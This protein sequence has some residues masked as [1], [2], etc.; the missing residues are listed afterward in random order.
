MSDAAEKN[1][2]LGK[3][4]FS[5]QDFKKAKECFTE[6]IESGSDFADVYNMLGIIHHDEGKLE[7]A[8]HYFEKALAINPNYSEASI[9]LAVVYSDIGKFDEAMRV[10][11][12]A[13]ERASEKSTQHGIDPYALGKLSNLH[14][15]LADIY[16]SMGLYAEA[17]EEYKKALKLNPDFGDIRTKLGIA[18]RDSGMLNEAIGELKKV[19]NDRPDYIPALLSLGLCYFKMESH[20]AA[21][22][23][24][25]KILDQEKDNKTALFYLK[26]LKKQKK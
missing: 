5:N 12:E 17:I 6:L 25:S 26:M 9:N 22:K 20:D 23:T 14:A 18:L 1:Y 4:A 21:E 11:D 2:W 3:E 24:W 19:V 15:D 8:V 10:Y 7:K 13:K 16:Y